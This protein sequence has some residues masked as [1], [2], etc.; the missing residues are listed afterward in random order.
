MRAIP[1][2]AKQLSGVGTGRRA[3]RRQLDHGRCVGEAT[4]A[5]AILGA[6]EASGLRT[7]RIQPA[8]GDVRKTIRDVSAA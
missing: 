5:I 6:R 4:K 2:V 3:L 7:S 8:R 1:Y